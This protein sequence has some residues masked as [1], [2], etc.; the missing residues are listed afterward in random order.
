MQQSQS[1]TLRNVVNDITSGPHALQQLWRGTLPSIIRTGF[2]SALYFTGLNALRDHARQFPELRS[3]SLSVQSAA[4]HSSALP[5]LSNAANLVTGATARVA[6]GFVL[7]PVT[8]I[9]VRYESSLYAY[10]SIWGAAQAVVRSEGIQGLFTGF[11]AT[12]ARDAPYA[13]LFVLFYE[14]MKQ[15]LSLMMAPE[16]GQE[17]GLGQSAAINFA[18]GVGA[19]GVAT[20]ITNPFDA[21]KTRVQLM[22]REYRNLVMACK[23]MLR[24]EGYRSFL[25]GLGLRMA[26]KAASSALAWTLYED[27]IRRARRY[28]LRDH[29]QAL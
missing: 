27:L 26:R 16:A 23:R 15:G 12:A 25:D 5:K 28:M 21:V 11:G 24:E 9:K 29:V 18:S 22:P 7:M 1:A 19:A 6:A 20:A 10:P 13:G 8:V 4:E 2:G 17:I 3:P 14:Q